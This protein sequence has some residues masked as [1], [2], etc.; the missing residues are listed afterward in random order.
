MAIVPTVRLVPVRACAIVIRPS[1]TTLSRMNNAPDQ[2]SKRNHAIRKLHVKMGMRWKAAHLVAV[3]KTIAISTPG[4]H[5]KSASHLA[6]PTHVKT[7][8]DQDQEA[9]HVEIVMVK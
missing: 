6:M 8:P 4:H 3:T 1:V 5:G 9:V 7:Q 2:I